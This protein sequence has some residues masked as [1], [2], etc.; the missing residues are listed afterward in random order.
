MTTTIAFALETFVAI[1]LIVTVGTCIKLE[2]RLAQL[3]LNEAEMR[4]TVQDLFSATERAER[5]ITTIKSAIEECDSALADRLGAA[6]RQSQELTRRVREGGEVLQRI[7]RIVAAGKSEG[8]N[9]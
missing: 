2:K 5:A 3:R 7:G 4:K 6:E 8:I 9:A 1:L